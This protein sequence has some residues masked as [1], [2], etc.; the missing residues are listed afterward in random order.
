MIIVSENE[1][2]NYNFF[3]HTRTVIFENVLILKMLF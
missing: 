2:E 1:S 3:A